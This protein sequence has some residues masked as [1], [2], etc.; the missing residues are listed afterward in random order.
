MS[1]QENGKVPFKPT[2]ADVMEYV[3]KNCFLYKGQCWLDRK[4]YGHLEEKK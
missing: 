2:F 1:G 4:T 3:K